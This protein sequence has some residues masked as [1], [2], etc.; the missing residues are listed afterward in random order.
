MKILILIS[1]LIVFI[2]VI[3]ILLIATDISNKYMDCF[4][5]DENKTVCNLNEIGLPFVLSLVLIGVFVLIDVFVI[6][7]MFSIITSKESPA[8]LSKSL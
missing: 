7:S 1:L 3:F 4:K 5:T 6:Y 8:F 2:S